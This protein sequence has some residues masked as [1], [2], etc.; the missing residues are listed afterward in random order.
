MRRI[1]ETARIAH[2]PGIE[3]RQVAEHDTVPIQ[4]RHAAVA[5]RLPGGEPWVVGKPLLHA[6][7]VVRHLPA[8]HALAGCAGQRQLE[9]GEQLPVT[10]NCQRTKHASLG[11]ELGDEGVGDAQRLGHAADERPQESLTGFAFDAFDDLAQRNVL[12]E[13]RLRP[14]RA[15]GPMCHLA[16]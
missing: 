16:G 1:A 8:Q 11:V 15:H 12:V 14:A 5:L 9:V 6:I 4:E 2:R 10:P 7:R 3:D 13:R